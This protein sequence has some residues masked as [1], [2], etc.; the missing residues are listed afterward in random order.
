VSPAPRSAGISVSEA[1]FLLGCTP[2]AV[3]AAL[4]AGTLRGSLIGGQWVVE[5]H[6]VSQLQQQRTARAWLSVIA[7]LDLGHGVDPRQGIPAVG[8]EVRAWLFAQR[9]LDRG[10]GPLLRVT[11]AGRRWLACS[12]LG[13]G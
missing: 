2:L 1:A 4:R 9:Y 5:G 10:P 6:H 7:K 12:A 11:E 3:K 13:G 8:G